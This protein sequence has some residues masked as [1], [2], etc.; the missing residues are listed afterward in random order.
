MDFV[1]SLSNSRE[2]IDLNGQY[3]CIDKTKIKE[4][5]YQHEKTLDKTVENVVQLLG[6]RG[7]TI[8][9]AESCTG[10][11]LS[12][13][14]TAVP[15]ASRVFEVGVCTYATHF[16]TKLLGVLPSLIEEYG[17]VSANVAAAMV[18]GLLTLSGG[19]DVCLSVTGLAGPTGGSAQ[20]PVGT[21]YVGAIFTGS[22]YVMPLQ[23][24]EFDLH[25]RDVI[26][27]GTLVC[28]MGLVHDWLLTS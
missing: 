7:Q 24:G 12:A 16:K 18:Q 11:M 14:I 13:A 22:T 4:I 1:E 20:T 28:A 25:T 2:N 10:G 17:V 3:I 19:A 5:Y 8:A 9:T 23:L 27:R 21:V 26:R 6:K 15:N